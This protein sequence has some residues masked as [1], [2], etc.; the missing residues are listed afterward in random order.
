METI[1]TALLF[2]A[3]GVVVVILFT[4]ILT[5]AKGGDFHRRNANK[6][7]NLRVLAQGI[8]LIFFALLLLLR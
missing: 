5:F 3:M 4:G 8:A 2:C 7:M 6:L 1:L